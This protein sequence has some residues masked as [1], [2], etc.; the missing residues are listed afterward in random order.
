[1]PPSAGLDSDAPTDDGDLD[2]GARRFQ[3]DIPMSRHLQADVYL[4]DR[5]KSAGR[6]YQ[7]RRRLWTRHCLSLPVAALVTARCDTQI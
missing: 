4:I 1:M 3:D 5:L 7:D 2:R 6:P